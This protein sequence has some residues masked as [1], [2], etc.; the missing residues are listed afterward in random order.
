MALI[1]SNLI[2][3]PRYPKFTVQKID[4]AS[5]GYYFFSPIQMSVS[6]PV[7]GFYDIILD[8]AGHL[9]YTKEYESGFIAGSLSLNANGRYSY[10]FDKKFYVMDSLFRPL[11]TVLC[12]N[13]IYTDSHELLIL[14]NGNYAL[15]GYENVTMDLSHLFIF[16]KNKSLGLTNAKVRCG[17]I[18]ELSPQK[19]VIFEWHSKLHYKFDDADTTYIENL[20]DIDWTHFNSLEL[21]RD[22]NYMVSVKHFNEVTK[23]N[24]TTGQI[25]W[26]LGGKR[27]Q[28]AFLNDSLMFKGQHHVK[29]TPNRFLSLFDNGEPNGRHPE[30]A[31]EYR[32]D[33]KS[34]NLTLIWSHV[35]NPAIVSSGYGSFQKLPG[36]NSLISY[37]RSPKSKIVFN[38]VYTNGRPFFEVSSPDSLC[39][40]RAANYLRLPAELPQPEISLQKE[41]NTTVLSAPEGFSAYYWSTGEKTRSI[42]IRKN[43]IYSV[44]VPFGPD[45]YLHAKPFEIT[46]F[47]RTSPGK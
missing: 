38:A 4:T 35:N 8:K 41:N 33:E 45:G 17:I 10:F 3:Q 1:A 22:G 21:D 16:K 11:D 27:N 46:S 20:Y 2:A 5:K 40:Y 19:K 29:R 31:K 12:Q 36:R 32:L 43:G 30:I 26:R 7:T 34:M 15:L 39:S 44:A 23:V 28:F 18:Q 6:G 14:P 13:D 42:T 25:I 9:V 24:R 37:G 47:T